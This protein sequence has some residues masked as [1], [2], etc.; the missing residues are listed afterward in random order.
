MSSGVVTSLRGEPTATA[1]EPRPFARVAEMGVTPALRVRFNPAR[2]AKVV[3]AVAGTGVGAGA[4]SSGD[5]ARESMISWL[6]PFRL[7]AAVVAG[8]LAFLATG[9]L[10]FAIAIAWTRRCSRIDS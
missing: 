8:V 4:M 10:A 1:L 5:A 9:A 6:P 3:G 2:G 7:I